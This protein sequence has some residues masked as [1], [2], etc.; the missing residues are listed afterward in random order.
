MRLTALVVYL[1]P[2]SLQGC[3][4]SIF[5]GLGFSYSGN[6]GARARARARVC[7]CVCVCERECVCVC[8]CVCAPTR[9]RVRVRVLCV[10]FA[11]L[12]VCAA[13]VCCMCGVSGCARVLIF[14]VLH[15]IVW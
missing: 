15:E 7:V 9:V 12:Q 4:R 10:C 2:K 13:G 14:S 1:S 11:V 6:L 3:T 5:S 8:V